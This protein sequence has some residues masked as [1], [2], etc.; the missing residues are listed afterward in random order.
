MKVLTAK[1]MQQTE[2]R[3]TLEA[4]IPLVRLMDNAGSA[5]ARV[6]RNTFDVR[7]AKCVVVCGNGN[8][9][10]DGLVVARKLQEAEADVSIILASGAPR[11]QDAQSMLERVKML[12]IPLYDLTG[13]PTE[14]GVLLSSCDLIVDAIF[15]IG[16]HG[17]VSPFHANLIDRINR[18]SA[19]VYS[20]DI[21]S[22]IHADT[23]DV[24][25]CC[26]HA[27]C[28][29]SFTAPKPAHV[30]VQCSAY[31]GRI[32]VVDIGI[33]QQLLQEASSSL[34]LIDKD[35]VRNALPSRRIDANKGD[36]GR[37]LAFC[38]SYCMPGAALLAS[39]AAVRSGVGLVQLAIN[40]QAY[41]LVA[42]K[43]P[44][45]T[46]LPLPAKSAVSIDFDAAC[47]DISR[48]LSRAT[49]V[50][51][52]CG[53]STDPQNVALL[54]FVLENARCP[55]VLDADGINLL[56]QN[57]DLLQKA[58]APIVMTPHPGEMA[59]LLGRSVEEVQSSRLDTAREAASR[60]GAVVVL[61]GAYTLV[62]A[63]SGLVLCNNTGNP[64]LATAGSGDVLAGMIAA[65]AAQGIEGLDAA[66]SGVYLHGL[67]G[68]ACAARLS[69]YAM[70]PSDL[71][72]ELPH[73]LLHLFER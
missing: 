28:T 37:L 56:A 9:G 69:Q 7:R 14:I 31:C 11:T 16:F 67:A 51:F 20:L 13:S 49:C 2:A 70:T 65:F 34:A 57:I 30:N 15:G 17:D 39:S 63:P 43:I 8:N 68:D 59:R 73:T 25:L 18:S 42:G 72:E 66:M 36:F 50:L 60:F 62:A 27:D 55:I 22:G 46:Y 45:I 10:G 48:A 4:G 5:A 35:M 3:V 26:V 52:G 71:V 6:I 61:K 40:A 23:G 29:I 38:G 19:V 1:E 54:A 47:P 64:G 58:S 33:P 32:E 53:I 12:D 44:E 41:P 21:P 24:G